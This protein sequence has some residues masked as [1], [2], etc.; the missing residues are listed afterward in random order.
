MS[1]KMCKLVLIAFIMSLVLTFNIAL[2]DTVWYD[3]FDDKDTD[4]WE[5]EVLDWELYDAF[6]GEVAEFDTSDGTLK[7]PG[8]TPGNIWYLATYNS[9][10]DIGTWMFDVEVLDTPWEHFYIFLMA[11]DW[12]NYVGVDDPNEDPDVDQLNNLEEYN[13]YSDPNNADSD[14]D[15]LPDGWEVTHG[16]DPTIDDRSGDA[17]QDGYSNLEEYMA[18][19]LPDDPSSRPEPPNADAGPNRMWVGVF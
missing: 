16:L 8:D 3:N 19:A 17:D 13:N 2:A 5:T 10:Q 7:A 14:G 12:E 9:S 4:G 6:T 15:T 1:K 11:D 18:G